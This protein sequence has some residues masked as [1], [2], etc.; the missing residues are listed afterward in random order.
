[1]VEDES[2]F[3]DTELLVLAERNGFRIH[4]VPVD[5]V[6][7][8]DSRVDVVS[9]A[10]ADLAG[11]WRLLRRIAAGRA[12]V[13]IA[14]GRASVGIAAGRASVGS[15]GGAAGTSGTY[16][17]QPAADMEL[18]G[19]L[20]RFASIGVVST[21]LFAAL[22]AVLTGPLG[23]V[24]ADVVALG[25]CAMANTA[26]NRRLTFSLRGRPGR[27]RQY[28]TSLGLAALPLALTLAAVAGLALAGV[29]TLW[30][31][32]LVLAA[33]SAAAALAR[34]VLLRRWVFRP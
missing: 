32:V 25:V 12:S 2:W 26:A 33:V 17:H 24:L 3:F 34:F 28:A 18:A 16:D 6:D 10:K 27:A 23:I 11:V 31:R 5:W 14:A 1:L 21:L 4:E 7:D 19:Q 30:P 15:A 20:A 8:P 29:G 9:T 22:L 13:G